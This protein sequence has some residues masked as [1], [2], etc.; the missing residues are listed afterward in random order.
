MDIFTRIVQGDSAK[1]TE[2]LGDMIG[3]V[4]L[5]VT[6]P[7]YFN[8]IS[9]K[10]H[11]TKSSSNYRDRVAENY[12]LDY[13]LFLDKV[14]NE[15][16]VMLKPGGVLCINVGS[17]LENG[18]HLPLP[19]DVTGQILGDNNNFEY[20]H[21]LVWHK[22]T[23][24]VKRAGGV[25]SR[26]FPGYW[27]P[28]ILTEQILI[29]R[30]MGGKKKVLNSDVPPDWLNPIW[31]IAPVPSRAAKHP[32]PFPEE[33]PHRL[34]RLFTHRGDIVLDPFNGSGT[35]TKAAF[36]LNRSVIGVDL[37]KSYVSLAKNRLLGDSSL[38]LSQLKLGLTPRT[39][40]IPGPS[41]GKT[42]H[43]SGVAVKR[44]SEPS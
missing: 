16:F 19:H 14:W 6:S 20:M 40:F 29:F 25:I 4:S 26:P 23:A 11:A 32:A 41:Q 2:F 12:A 10:V 13:L 27:Y 33:I 8:A 34:V 17:V 5:I 38:R 43:G 42:R 35:T 24:G 37:Q 7:P 18:N 9:Y 28:N 39:E 1:M 15:C 30:K 21:T 31:D 36:D 3:K 44:A 22:V